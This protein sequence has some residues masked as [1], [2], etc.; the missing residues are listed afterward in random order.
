MYKFLCMK[1][2]IFRYL[3]AFFVFIGAS[4]F[5]NAQTRIYVKVRPTATVV[6]RPAPPHKN[7]VWIGDE[8]TVHNGVYAHVAGHWVAPRKAYVWVPGH[9]ADEARG[10]YWIPGHWKRV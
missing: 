7:Y 5:A 2:Q 8:W 6:A 9:W 4:Q 1:K 3:L 10:Y